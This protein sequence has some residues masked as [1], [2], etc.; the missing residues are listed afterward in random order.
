MT[1][2]WGQPAQA[3]SPGVRRLSARG[4]SGASG[5]EGEGGAGRLRRDPLLQRVALGDPGR[6]AA[7]ERSDAVDASSLQPERH[8]GARPFIGSTTEEDDVAAARDLL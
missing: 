5:S 2:R 4:P 6:V 7:F 8:P 3:T 1:P